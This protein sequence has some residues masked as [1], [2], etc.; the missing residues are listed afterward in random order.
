VRF[1]A[2]I[3]SDLP[4]LVITTHQKKPYYN[5]IINIDLSQEQNQVFIHFLYKNS[6]IIAKQRNSMMSRQMPVTKSCKI[7]DTGGI[8]N[9]TG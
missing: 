7:A 5:N 9:F 6:N 1:L 3:N 2:L 8:G 4:N